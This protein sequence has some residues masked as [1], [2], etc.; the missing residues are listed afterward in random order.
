V[1]AVEL[2]SVAQ[3]F[4]ACRLRNQAFGLVQDMSQGCLYSLSQDIH[5]AT[6]FALQPADD[7]ALA[8]DGLAHAL[9]LLGMG[10]AACLVA[11]Q[12]AFF[13]VGLLEFD[14]IGFL[15]HGGVHDHSTQLFLSDELEG[16]RHLHGAVQ[17]N[18]HAYFTQCLAKL[19]QLCVGARPLVLEV[20]VA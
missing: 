18:F 15:M 12:V 3:R 13:G 6:A 16:N 11:Q 17:Q 20:F 7:G 10:V 8:F 14:P 5:L 9:E 2:G 4:A 19:T 1:T